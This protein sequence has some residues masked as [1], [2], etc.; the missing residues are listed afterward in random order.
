[1]NWTS[2][3]LFVAVVAF[4]AYHLYTHREVREPGVETKADSKVVAGVSRYY[5]C[6]AAATRANAFLQEGSRLFLKPPVDAAAWSN[7]ESRITSAISEGDGLCTGGATEGERFAISEVREALA[8]MRRSVAEL[9]R[10]SRG[11]GGAE[12]VRFQEEVEGHLERARG[13]MR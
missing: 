13:A 9:N 5:T 12:L 8:A 3:I 7:S 6:M 4:I 10:A 1:M 11:E 2:R